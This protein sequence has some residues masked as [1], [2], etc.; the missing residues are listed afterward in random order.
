VFFRPFLHA[1]L[2]RAESVPAARRA[3]GAGSLGIGPQA[4][5]TLADLGQLELGVDGFGEHDVRLSVLVCCGW[6]SEF[7]RVVGAV[8]AAQTLDEMA[9]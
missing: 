4:C 1:T 7:A 6:I 2:S 9:R 3:K 8:R 5:V